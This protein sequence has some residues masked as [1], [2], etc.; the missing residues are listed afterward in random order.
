MPPA[1]LKEMRE[2][3][4][5]LEKAFIGSRRTGEPSRSSPSTRRISAAPDR[6]SRSRCA[7]RSGP[8]G[9]D[10]KRHRRAC[11]CGEPGRRH[12]LHRLHPRPDRGRGR[13]SRNLL[14]VSLYFA[15]EF[16]AYLMGARLPSRCRL[17]ACAPARRSASTCCSRTCRSRCRTSSICS[18]RS[19]VSCNRRLSRLCAGRAHVV[20]VHPRVA[21]A[22]EERAAALDP[23]IPDVR[24]DRPAVQPAGDGGA[25]RPAV[26]GRAG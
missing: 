10:A 6:D 1:M 26:A 3:T 14:N 20:F 7:T 2:K 15:W 25:A 16:S 18:P 9:L 11:P 17:C 21:L 23:A 12:C 8:I 5:G 19:A 13:V 22:R 4:V 24:S